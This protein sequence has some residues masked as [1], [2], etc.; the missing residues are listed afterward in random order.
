MARQLLIL[1]HAKAAWGA[2]NEDVARE[3]TDKGLA[4]AKR[5]GDWLQTQR[6]VP[7][8]VLCSTA[9][10]AVQT[11]EAVT[12]AAGWPP[13]PTQFESSL[14][15]AELPQLSAMLQNLAAHYQTV[16]LIGHNP[17][18]EELA[19]FISKTKL[20]RTFAGEL[21]ATANLVQFSLSADWHEL[22]A[23]GELRQLFRP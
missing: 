22:A 11:C 12:K 3:L 20:P 2:A 9:T 4:E 15:L 7:D 21:L 17:G 13:L 19:I 18:L 5:V 6:I 16:L 10:R 14:Y 1:R 8:L 23:Q